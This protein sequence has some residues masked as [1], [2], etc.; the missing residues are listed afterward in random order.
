MESR[1]AG[2]RSP[3][4]TLALAAALVVASCGGNDGESRGEPPRR[5][6]PFAYDASA[7]LGLVQRGITRSEGLVEREIAF[8]VPDGPKVTATL[9]QRAGT[10][11]RP[12]VVYLHGAGGSRRDMMP[13][14]RALARRGAVALAI[15]Q[16]EPGAAESQLVGIAALEAQ[17]DVS[18]R[19]VVSVRRALDVLA[20]LPSVDESRLA[21]VGWSGGGRVAALAAGAEPRLDAV[22]LMSVGALPLARY[23]DAAPPELRAE[24]RRVLVPVDPLR[25]L[26]RTAA[27]VLL[28]NG[29]QDEIVPAEALR[30]VAGTAPESRELRWYE[31]GHALDEHAHRDQTDWLARRLQ[32][33]H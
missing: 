17:R 13:L 24:V 29:R 22:V 18:A 26:G 10:A 7:P 28:Q 25:W 33:G 11:K 14:A 20:S 27:K 5:T 6:L 30:A 4:V 2:I 3:S 1:Q 16:P 32:L 9:V 19:A 15:D 12:G 31:A 21:V 8:S 23:V